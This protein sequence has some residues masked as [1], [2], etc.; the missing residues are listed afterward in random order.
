MFVCLFQKK[1]N[2]QQLTLDMKTKEGIKKPGKGKKPLY[3]TL[4][5]INVKTQ[6]LVLL[7]SKDY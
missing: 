4:F 5:A 3:K 6:S 2:L 7:I 1:S